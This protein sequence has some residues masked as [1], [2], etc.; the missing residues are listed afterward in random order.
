[1]CAANFADDH[2]LAGL[3]GTIGQS[4][5]L[6]NIVN[7]VA[8]NSISGVVKIFAGGGNRWRLTT[9][10]ANAPSPVGFALT[11]TAVNAATA[12]TPITQLGLS[13][14]VGGELAGVGLGGAFAV[15]KLGYDVSS[16]VYALGECRK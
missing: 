4:G 13:A 15:A 5:V 2:S 9:A 12:P 11:A 7:G 6:A 3:A 10:L 14:S 8:G 1:M 16:F